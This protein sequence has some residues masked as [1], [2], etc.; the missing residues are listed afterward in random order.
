M[1]ATDEQ[2]KWMVGGT[3]RRPHHGFLWD[4]KN[5]ADRM[6][7]SEDVRTSPADGLNVEEDLNSYY[8]QRLDGFPQ[9]VH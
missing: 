1:I 3:S 2:I 5:G 8:L 6:R 7:Y 4:E 9:F